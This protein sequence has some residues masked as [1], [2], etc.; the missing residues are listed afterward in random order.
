M[1]GRY[2][3]RSGNIAPNI[4][5]ADLPGHLNAPVLLD[6]FCGAGGAAMGYHLTGFRVVGVDISWQPRYPFE[7]RQADAMT[8]PLEGFDAIHASPPCQAY[9]AM[10]TS[11]NARGDHPQL[12]QPVRERLREAGVPWVMENVPG[13]PLEPLFLMCG[14][15]FGLGVPGYQLRRHRWFEV[16]GFWAMSQPC[17]HSGPVIGIYGDH[18]RDRRRGGGMAVTSPLTSARPRWASNGWRATS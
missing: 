5:R 18:G 17:Q 11:W 13:A 7:F 6:L 2:H 12:I 9:S 15:A 4:R 16:S 10:R 14:S 3:D 1:G 8:Y